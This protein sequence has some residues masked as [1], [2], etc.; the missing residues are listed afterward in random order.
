MNTKLI[1]SLLLFLL[2]LS[3]C[4]SLPARFHC[5]GDVNIDG[6]PLENA[7]IVFKNRENSFERSYR[8]VSGKFICQK[9]NGL[10]A[11]EYD[12][13][14]TP[15]EAEFEEIELALKEGKTSPQWSSPIPPEL[16]KPGE[17]S[18]KIETLENNQLNFSF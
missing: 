6:E 3:G 10:E 1:T 13:F 11:G 9:A 14:L 8:V 16:S 4:Q 2:V 17:W 15:A 7:N 18:A 5:E 12:V